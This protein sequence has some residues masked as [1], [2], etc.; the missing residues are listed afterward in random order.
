MNNKALK[1]GVKLLLKTG[2][3]IFLAIKNCPILHSGVKII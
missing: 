2:G 1:L 3:D